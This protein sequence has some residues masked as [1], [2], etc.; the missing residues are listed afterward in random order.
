MREAV[1]LVHGIWSNGMDMWR[2]C[3]NL[4]RSGYEC[5]IFKYQIWGKPPAMIADRLHQHIEKMDAPVVHFVGHSFGGIVLLHMFHQFPFS[6][7]GRI[8][9]MGAPVNGSSVGR[10]LSRLAI[11]RWTLGKTTEQGILGDVPE[12]KGWQDIGVIAG[13]LPM[14]AG[15]LAGGPAMP[16]DGTVAVEETRLKRATDFITLPVS[17]TGMLFSTRVADQVVTF[18]RSGKFGDVVGT[19]LLDSSVA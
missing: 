14:G 17:H 6:R 12:W 10:R 1:V 16:H 9:L 4:S 19:P 13:T 2:L 15:M 3:Q 8:V 11:T 5:S 7:N 18:L